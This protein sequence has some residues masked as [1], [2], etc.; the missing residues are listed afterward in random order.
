MYY[1]L[2]RYTRILGSKHVESSNTVLTVGPRA[3]KHYC[4]ISTKLTFLQVFVGQFRLGVGRHAMNNSSQ[5]EEEEEQKK[6]L[7][8]LTIGGPC[9]RLA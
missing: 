3:N 7:N 1:E 9:P 5:Q 2:Q 4:Y 6:T 8:A